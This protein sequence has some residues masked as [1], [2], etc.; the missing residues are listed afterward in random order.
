MNELV[1]RAGAGDERARE[2]LLVLLTPRLE[3]IVRRYEWVN[4]L[5]LDDLKQEAFMAVIEGLDRVNINIGSSSEYLLK[6]ARWRLLDCLKKILRKKQEEMEQMATC[7]PTDAGLKAEIELLDRRLSEVQKQVLRYLA[8]GFTWREIGDK[9]GF[10]AANVSH[11]L[12]R[13]RKLYGIA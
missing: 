1:R 4:G 5:D 11:H 10:T 13:I 12:K 3:K 9:M 8:E 6:F 7:I 2:E